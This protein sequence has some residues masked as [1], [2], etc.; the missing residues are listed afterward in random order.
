VAGSSNQ[1]TWFSTLQRGRVNLVL[2]RNKRKKITRLEGHK[3]SSDPKQ[4]TLKFVA[5]RLAASSSSKWCQEHLRPL[6]S[7]PSEWW[8]SGPHEQAPTGCNVLVWKLSFLSG[9]LLLS[10]WISKPSNLLHN[11]DDKCDSAAMYSVQGQE[12]FLAPS[13]SQFVLQ[14]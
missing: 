3:P 8:P 5:P 12:S 14:G 4:S 2:F 1:E 13:N 10:H 11:R 6:S 7:E 9:K